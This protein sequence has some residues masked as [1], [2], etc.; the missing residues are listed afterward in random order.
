[1]ILWD[2]RRAWINVGLAGL[3]MT[4]LASLVMWLFGPPAAFDPL[5]LV[6]NLWVL[7]SLW[8]IVLDLFDLVE[9]DEGAYRWAVVIAMAVTSPLLVRLLAYAHLPA[10][11]PAWLT[12][13]WAG[14]F[15]WNAGPPNEFLAILVN[16]LL[17]VRALQADRRNLYFLSLSHRVRWMWL[18]VVGA[19]ALAAARTGYD[20]MPVVLVSFPAGLMV[21]IIGRIEEKSGTVATAGRDLSWGHLAQCLLFTLV[22]AVLGWAPQLL[23][24][25]VLQGWAE[26]VLS[27]IFF[28]V[29]QG[30][31][32]LV[33]L[34]Y[35]VIV[36][37]IEA[38]YNLFEPAD[39]GPRPY[40]GPPELLQRDTAPPVLEGVT[41]LPLWAV[42]LFRFAG[43]LFLVGIAVLIVLLVARTIRPRRRRRRREDESV[44]RGGGDALLRRGLEQLRDVIDMARRIGVNQQLLAAI[45]VQNI[46]ANLSRIAANRGHPRRTYQSP[47]RYLP[48]LVEAFGGHPAA[49]TRITN[50][51]MRVHYGDQTITRADLRQ[52]QADYQS[53]RSQ[54][55]HHT[56]D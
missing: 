29:M 32:L 3:E 52:I 27:F 22:I 2:R 17:W 19:A 56:G 7:Q 23:P 1:M 49:L 10:G 51:Y 45:S 5:S 37:A 25:D 34:V 53:V 26:I 43:I 47:D 28:I 39:G 4:L 50:A 21:L 20:P 46:Y 36:G 8:M 38:I 54:Q 44:V 15:D 55:Q 41:E 6:A 31:L 13:A 14:L 48:D 12:D 40:F 30:I 16:F 24:F 9:L 33:F 11:N 18:F 42:T 35:P